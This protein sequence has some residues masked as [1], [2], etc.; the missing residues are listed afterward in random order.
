MEANL[1][2]LRQAVLAEHADVGIAYDGDGDRIGVL[3]ER[4]RVLWG[5]QLMIILSRAL[6]A[7]EGRE[8]L[9]RGGWPDH[10][11]RERARAGLG[12]EVVV[13]RVQRLAGLEHHIVGDIHHVADAAHP[14]LLE[15]GPE[16]VR[17]RADLD[18]L[19]DAGHVARAQVRCLEADANQIRRRRGGRVLRQGRVRQAQRVAGQRADLAGDADDAIQVGPVGGD[20]Q[21]INHVA[22][23]PAEILGERLAHAGVGRE[24]EQS[25]DGVRQPQFLGGAHHAVGLDAANLAHLDRHGSFARLGGQRHAGQDQRDFIAGREILRAADDLPLAPAVLDAAHRE[26]VGVGMLI[27][28]NDLR[29]HDAVTFAADFDHAFDLDSQHGQPLG[30]FRGRPV[31]IHVLLEPVQCNFHERPAKLAIPTAKIKSFGRLNRECYG[32]STL[33]A[34]A[35]GAKSFTFRVRIISA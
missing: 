12:Q 15:G 8:F 22:A 26:L 9:A 7:V 1:L 25:L 35:K 16:P 10:D 27:A 32:H 2:D 23:R 6:L 29:H 19:D 18:A 3:D 21:V 5:D 28:C 30:E 33:A 13:E 24:D 17:A 14:H 20:F 11:G 34:P 31:E 4:G